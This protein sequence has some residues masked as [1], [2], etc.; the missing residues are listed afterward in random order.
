MVLE[1]GFID[2]GVFTVMPF[3]SIV[4]MSLKY[5]SQSQSVCINDWIIL[6]STS[7]ASFYTYRQYHL[8]WCRV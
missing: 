6:F 1:N 2:V 4:T 7:E 8:F 5:G 3:E